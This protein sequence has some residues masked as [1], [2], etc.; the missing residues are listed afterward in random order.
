MRMLLMTLPTVAPIFIGSK[1]P[2]LD[3]NAAVDP[4]PFFFPFIASK[5]SDVDDNVID[6]LAFFCHS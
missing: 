5:W 1:W 2:D 6:D 3:V 4:I